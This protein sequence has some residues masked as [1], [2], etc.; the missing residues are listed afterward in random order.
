[1]TNPMPHHAP[2]DDRRAIE[3]VVLRYCRGIDR[4]DVPAILS[5]YHDDGIDH[6]TGYS[7]PAAD[8]VAWAVPLLAQFGGTMHMIGNHLAEIKGDAAVVETYGSAIHWGDPPDDPRR[9]FTTGFRY[10]DHMEKRLGRWAIV[11]RWAVREWTR[12]DAGR[13]MPK[14]ADGPSARKDGDDPLCLLQRKLGIGA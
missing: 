11:E 9:N 10:I 7:G 4:L 8:F 13:Y 14:E 3:E 6:H 12:S 2:A 1:M 5:A